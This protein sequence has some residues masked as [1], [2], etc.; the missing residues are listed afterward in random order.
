MIDHQNPMAQLLDILHVMAGKQ[1]HDVML[2]IVDTQKFAD[3]LL[4][5][6]IQPDRRFIE[7]KHARL[8]NE[9]SNEFHL[10]AF[11]QGQFA[12][13]HVHFVSHFQEFR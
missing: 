12:H 1:R 9:R 2:L 10:H 6:H 4:T 3:A 11:A 8:V 13:H 5:D 7:K